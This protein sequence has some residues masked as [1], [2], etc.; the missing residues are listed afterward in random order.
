MRLLF[1]PLIAAAL[2]VVPGPAASAA[3]VRV[4]SP[5]AL[6]SAMDKANPGDTITLADGSY[7][8]GSTLSIKRSGTASAPVTIAVL[9]V[10]LTATSSR[11]SWISRLQ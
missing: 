9:P 4:T 8:A 2:V 11:K 5:A 1:V 6:Q 3:Q 10:K 7:S